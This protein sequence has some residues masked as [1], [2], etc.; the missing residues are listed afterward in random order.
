[1]TSNHQGTPPVTNPRDPRAIIAATMREVAQWY[2]DALSPDEL[3]EV[4]YAVERDDGYSQCP[5]CEEDPCDAGCPLEPF[6]P[7]YADPVR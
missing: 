5:V 2:P 4:A 3:E 7:E 6:R 1:M